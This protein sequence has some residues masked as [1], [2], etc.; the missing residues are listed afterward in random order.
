MLLG[1]DLHP[2]V[3]V[4]GPSIASVIALSMPTMTLRSL[5]VP[6]ARLTRAERELW[7]SGTFRSYIY[8][9]V[10]TDQLWVLEGVPQIAR[11]ADLITLGTVVRDEPAEVVGRRI[12]ESI[13]VSLS[14]ALGLI[15]LND[16]DA[17]LERLDGEL[18]HG[19]VIV[20]G[21]SA[22]QAWIAAERRLSARL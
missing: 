12:D 14:Q 19:L 8:I 7:S 1:V 2:L 6:S 5:S 3:S 13:D 20:S 11:V 17:L 15:A 9:P 16:P 21:H 22:R 10:F 4:S 18:E